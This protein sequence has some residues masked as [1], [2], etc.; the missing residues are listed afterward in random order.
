MMS[1]SL[2][3]D[4]AKAGKIQKGCT[5][6]FQ[7]LPSMTDM[8]VC[9][10]DAPSVVAASIMKGPC[11]TQWPPPE[12]AKKLMTKELI[13]PH[14]GRVSA[15]EMLTKTWAIDSTRPEPCMMAMMPA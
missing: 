2:S 6:S 12:G 10:C 7:P 3:L 13:R 9:A 15:L 14:S 5:R 4:S 11:S 1:L 8:A